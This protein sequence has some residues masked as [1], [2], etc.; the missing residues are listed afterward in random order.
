MHTSKLNEII[1][2]GLIQQDSFKANLIVALEANAQ[3][4]TILADSTK[5]NISKE[6]VETRI[7]KPVESFKI[8]LTQD[9]H[10]QVNATI[11][12]TRYYENEEKANKH[13]WDSS[14]N[15]SE[16]YSIEGYRLENFI[17]E[18]E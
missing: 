3:L 6:E 13:D 14:H 16:K 5:P 9:F 1:A 8:Q 7:G 12:V 17:Y 10:W 2:T 4:A 18:V 11:R 15:Q